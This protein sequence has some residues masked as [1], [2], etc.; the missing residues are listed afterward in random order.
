LVLRT[1]LQGRALKAT[2]ICGPSSAYRRFWEWLEEG[3]FN[4][5]WRQGLLAYAWGTG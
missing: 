5:L 4:E 3:V 1:G 2:G